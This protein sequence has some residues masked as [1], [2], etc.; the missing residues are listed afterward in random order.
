MFGKKKEETFSDKLIKKATNSKMRLFL[1]EST[2]PRILEAAAVAAQNDICT[3]VLAGSVK[4]FD[5]VFPAKILKKLQFL[6]M[7]DKNLRAKY[8][9]KILEI[10]AAKGMTADEA[11]EIV[12]RPMYFACA[13]LVC[14]DIDG[15]VAGAITETADVLR[16]AF[17]IVKTAKD[18]G[19]ASSSMIFEGDKSFGENG[20]LVFGDIAVNPN[21]TSEQLCDI[22]IATAKTAK[23]VA[24]ISPKVA[25][26]S[27]STKAEG[28][29]SNEVQKVKDAFLLVRRKQPSLVVDGEIQVDAAVVPSVAKQ[30]APYGNLKGQANVLVFPNLD[31]GNIGYKIAARF[32]KMKA[33]GPI[34]QG[35]A[36]PVNDLSRGASADEIV[37]VLAITAL[38]AKQ[39]KK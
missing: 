5:E 12:K 16:P 28:K 20:I 11:A 32:G 37:G 29:V 33:F 6:D 13:A 9:S 36:L 18:V 25:L 35:L 17:Q 15:V 14:G 22:A 2:D 39:A 4:Q 23:D 26:L 38:Q 1:P 21:P 8:A 31:A 19:I 7:S 27:Y 30:K 24:G 10:R 3:V 34:V